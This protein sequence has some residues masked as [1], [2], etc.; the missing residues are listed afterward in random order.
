MV[1]GCLFWFVCVVSVLSRLIVLS[2]VDASWSLVC[3]FWWVRCVMNML[4]VF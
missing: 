1:L 3:F 2:T 4:S